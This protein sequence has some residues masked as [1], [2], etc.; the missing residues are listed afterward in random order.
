MSETPEPI[1]DKQVAFDLLN[2]LPATVT[3]HEI[4]EE[5]SILAGIREGEADIADG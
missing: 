1:S 3:L 4:V 2:D 5:L